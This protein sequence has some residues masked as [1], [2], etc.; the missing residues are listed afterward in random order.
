LLMHLHHTFYA[1]RKRI[2]TNSVRPAVNSLAPQH[3]SSCL[4]I[5]KLKIADHGERFDTIV[6]NRA[7]KRAWVHH[8]AHKCNSR[9]HASADDMLNFCSNSQ[10]LAPVPE[11]LT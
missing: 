8:L 3:A 2:Y 10:E 7:A 1:K 9:I 6:T 5:S 11:A 4:E